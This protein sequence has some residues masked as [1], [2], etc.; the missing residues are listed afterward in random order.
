MH[1]SI[2]GDPAQG[3]QGV[4]NGWDA[5]PYIWIPGA[6]SYHHVNRY[7]EYLEELYEKKVEWLNTFRKIGTMADDDFSEPPDDWY[8]MEDEV[9]E[10]DEETGNDDD[11][12]FVEASN[13]LAVE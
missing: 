4:R 9:E 1:I 13:H 10:E 7:V 3:Y 11:M 8:H 6:L 2:D 12:V 5:K